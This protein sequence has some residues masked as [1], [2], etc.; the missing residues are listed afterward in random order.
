MAEAPSWAL[1]RATLDD[2]A[3]VARHRA[4]MFI[5]MHPPSAA[6][7]GR[8]HEATERFVRTALTRGEYV[9]WLAHASGSPATVVA[10]AGLHRRPMLPRPSDDGTEVIEGIEGLVLNVFVDADWRRQGIAEALMHAILAWAPEQGIRRLVLHASD[11]GRPLYER[12]GFIPTSE[13]RW[14]G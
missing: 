5:E 11:A 2:A 4:D 12:M 7:A 1:R 14:P 10:G 6:I 8:I 3:I 13:M 9:G